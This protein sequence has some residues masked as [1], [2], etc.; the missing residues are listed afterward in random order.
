MPKKRPKIVCIGGGT[1]T[2]QV[3]LGLRRYPVELTAVVTM[4]DSGGSSGRLRRDLDI[5][6]PG[7]VRR[8][9]MA[10]SGFKLRKNTL[11]QLFNFRFNNG[12]LA[13]H[14]LGNL[15]LAALTQITGREDLAI[16]EAAKILEISGQVLPVTINKTE[17]CALLVDGTIIRGE[18]NIDF[19]QIRPNV[20]IKEVYLSPQG[21]IFTGAKK[22]ITEADLIVLGPGDL[23]TSIIPNLLVSGV[24]R[25]IARSK[26][27][28]VYICNLVT[29]HGE[30]DGF[31]VSDFVREIR[32]YLGKAAGKLSVVV[33]NTKL[34]LPT[35]VAK[36]YKKYKAEP[37]KFDRKNIEE[38]KIFTGS[39]ATTGKFIRHD[40]QKIARVIMRL[41]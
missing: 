3:L 38:L 28:V 22:A 12:E 4:S 17:L 34:K 32:K 40:P 5:L 30:T 27:K 20:P 29:K 21:K 35:S 18:K 16:S 10:L 26:A 7:D 1:G 33:V 8:A 15:L 2:Y 39:F 37:V 9:L 11:T 19:R 31:T 14:S 24:S 6:P 41:L 23:Y 36:W 13:G 25:A